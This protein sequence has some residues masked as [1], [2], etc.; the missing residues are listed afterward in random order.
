MAMH[1]PQV[2]NLIN[3]SGLLP[4]FFLSIILLHVDLNSICLLGFFSMFLKGHSLCKN[5]LSIL[6]ADEWFS[7]CG[8]ALIKSCLCGRMF[9]DMPICWRV[10]LTWGEVVKGFSLPSDHPTQLSCMAF[11]AFLI[12]QAQQCALFVLRMYQS[13]DLDIFIFLPTLL[14]LVLVL[15]FASYA[16]HVSLESKAL[17]IPILGSQ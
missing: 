5:S 11:Q 15:F 16:R 4:C 2:L 1:V 8:E 3:H 12:G 17:L 7:L 6:E 14:F 13:I 9:N 10:F